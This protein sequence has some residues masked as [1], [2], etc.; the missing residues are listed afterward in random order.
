MHELILPTE[1]KISEI[2]ENGSLSPNNYKKLTIINKKQHTIRD[3]LDEIPYFKGIE[4]GSSSYVPNSSQK[5]LRNSCINN[6]QFSV[7]K[8]KYICLNPK[9]FKETMISDGDVLLCTDANIGDCCM[10]ISD[11]ENLGFSS[12][13]VKLNFKKEKYKYYTM[14][15]MRDDYFREQLNAKTPKGATIRHSGDLFMECLI[16]DAPYEWVYSIAKNV[17]KNIAYAEYISEKKLRKSEDLIHK[18]IMVK[19]Y[20]FINPSF[21]QL[22]NQKRLDSGI[23][24]DT[25]FQWRENVRNYKNG[26]FNLDEFGFKLKRGPNLAKRDLGRSIQTNEYRTGYNVLIYPSDISSA[27]YIQ[28]VSYLGARNPIWFLGT[29]DILFSSEGTIGKTFAVCDETM[30]FTTNFHGTI[31]KPKTKDIPLEKS[32]FLALYLNYIRQMNIFKKMSVGANGGSFA[33]GYWDNIRIPNVSEMFMNKLAMLYNNKISL[34]PAIFDFELLK[35]AGIYQ[36]NDFLIKC[37]VLLNQLCNDIKNDSLQ[38]KEFYTHM[39]DK[40]IT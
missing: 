14:A 12:G 18:E 3:Y 19:K 35:K 13:I 20:P 4:P 16:P 24:S 28:K 10:Y 31:I 15:F 32:I 36:L 34:N 21:K 9:Y 23:Y 17:I 7:D 29:R 30:R 37:K 8:N 38:E 11:G 6:I 27:G 1:V 5:F 39:M 33:V 22:Q 26:D 40:K 25:V 2:K